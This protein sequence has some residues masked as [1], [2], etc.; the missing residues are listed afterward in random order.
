MK[1]YSTLTLSILAACASTAPAS[2]GLFPGAEHI[3]HAAHK[4]QQSVGNV[5]VDATG[6]LFWGEAPAAGKGARQKI[7]DL[8]EVTAGVNPDT[9]SRILTE[10]HVPPLP[11]LAIQQKPLYYMAHAETTSWARITQEIYKLP[12]QL[13]TPPLA[14]WMQQN[15]H[16]PEAQV[17]LKLNAVLESWAHI[18]QIGHIRTPVDRQNELRR[19]AVAQVGR[20]HISFAT[21]LI[22]QLRVAP[23]QRVQAARIAAQQ[24][25]AREGAEAAALAAFMERA[26]E[27]VIPAPAPETLFSVYGDFPLLPTIA[28]P[29]PSPVGRPVLAQS[30]DALKAILKQHPL[31]SSLPLLPAGKRQAPDLVMRPPAAAPLPLEVMSLD[32][33]PMFQSEGASTIFPGSTALSVSSFPIVPLQGPDIAP[34]IAAHAATQTSPLSPDYSAFAG[35]IIPTVTPAEVKVIWGTPYAMSA[36]GHAN[37][38]TALTPRR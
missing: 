13:M 12:K 8:Q 4:V 30:A 2:A 29:P 28:A 14:D 32:G 6:R 37:S 35:R 7:I 33:I 15:A 3:R 20:A 17:I 1:K 31:P 11:F 36:Y 34:A 19:F 16:T 38:H 24:A 25:A 9:V 5:I 22:E 10:K 23:L 18:R 21:A 27:F 26:N